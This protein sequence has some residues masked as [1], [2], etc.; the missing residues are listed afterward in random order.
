MI[1]VNNF[2]GAGLEALTC[3]HMRFTDV[4]ATDESQHKPLGWFRVA[5]RPGADKGSTTIIMGKLYRVG[6]ALH[7]GWLDWHRLAGAV[8]VLACGSCCWNGLPDAVQG[9]KGLAGPAQSSHSL[10]HSLPCLTPSLAVFV[11]AHSMQTC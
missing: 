8:K 5:S 2:G 3:A 6:A 11:S 4:S 7:V 9:S 1:T 10:Q